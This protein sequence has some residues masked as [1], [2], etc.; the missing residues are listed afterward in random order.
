[1]KNLTNLVL[2]CAGILLSLTGCQEKVN[3]EES[4]VSGDYVKFS[5]TT[6]PQT[7]TAYSG[8]IKNGKE[9]IDWMAG[10]Q[11]LI[12]SDK[13]TVK[14]DAAPYF[15]GND[16]LAIYSIGSITA[17]DE[18]SV[19]TIEDNQ[20]A[21]LLYP[22]K[23]TKCQ[24]WGVYPGEVVTAAENGTPVTSFTISA[25][26]TLTENTN[27]TDAA[28]RDYVPDMKEAV[29]LAYVKDATA[30]KTV[31]IPF[32]PAYTAFEFNIKTKD[33]DLTIKSIELNST[34]SPLSGNFTAACGLD[35]VWSYTISD[36]AEKSVKATL[37]S[38]LTIK[39]DNSLCLTIFTLPQLIDELTV[40]FDTNEGT[41]SLK[42]VDNTPG[43]GK[44]FIKFDA[45]KKHRFNGLILPTGW[46][47][48]YIT[49]DLK[50]L[51]WDAVDCEGDTEDFPQAT[52]FSVSEKNGQ[53]I[54][55]AY[56]DFGMGGKNTPERQMWYFKPGQTILIHYKVMLPAGG[57]WEVEVVGGTADETKQADSALFLVKNV[58][59]DVDP[60]TEGA[61]YQL[62]GPIHSTGST[63]V[64]LEITYVGKKVVAEDGTVSYEDDGQQ[65]SFYFHT[66]VYS[67]ADRSGTKFNI[68][69]ETQ[70][71]DRGRGF[72]TFFVN[73]D[74]YPKSS[75]DSSDPEDPNI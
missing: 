22:D 1:M 49:L 36:S 54:Y 56:D 18:K 11:I 69:S 62:Y 37:P 38:P 60:E 48:S 44:P 21:G 28:I 39:P 25:N 47:F 4:V 67:G 7:R 15:S 5:A 66:Y 53:K 73:S 29:L 19:A 63:D 52:Q 32:Y 72:H 74:L 8:E 65:H 31:E 13:A 24:F 12:W 9:R 64:Y 46:Y 40:T 33:T 43:K 35:G 75:D 70:I 51:E 42:L 14:P 71:Y 16:N 6:A 34:K 3:N 30:A 26:Q 23:T 68:D 58:S 55:N 27:T 61:E 41:K 57:T 2:L 45:C 59:P 10:D 50:V 20:G 17:S